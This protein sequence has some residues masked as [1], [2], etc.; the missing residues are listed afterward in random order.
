MKTA[1]MS[2][3]LPTVSLITSEM[4]HGFAAQNVEAGALQFASR[5]SLTALPVKST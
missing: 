1:K 4:K 5:K 2:S 3:V